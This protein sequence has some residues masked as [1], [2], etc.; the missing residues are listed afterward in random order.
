MWL[1][2]QWSQVLN[3]QFS[4]V[5]QSLHNLVSSSSE[6]LCSVFAVE[7]WAGQ[8]DGTNPLL[9][10]GNTFHISF[11][12]QNILRWQ[13]FSYISFQ[14]KNIF[15]WWHFSYFCPSTKYLNVTLQSVSWW[16]GRSVTFIAYASTKL[17]E[18]IHISFL[19]HKIYLQRS[20]L[21][22]FTF[23]QSVIRPFCTFLHGNECDEWWLFWNE[24][25]FV[26]LAASWTL[27]NQLHTV[28]REDP[29][30]LDCDHDDDDDDR[31]PHSPFMGWA[32]HSLIICQRRMSCIMGFHG[33]VVSWD[34]PSWY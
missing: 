9:R 7:P 18:F 16:I 27:K 5:L 11:H 25:D 10:G 33:S 4:L 29:A 17:C 31:V 21:S 34:V 13:H 8:D 15:S 26:F 23:W 32:W 19:I 20:K 2:V 22:T 30:D 6:F 24:F 12:P 1:L 3:L 28:D 14:P